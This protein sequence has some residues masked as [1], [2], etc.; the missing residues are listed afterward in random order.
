MD[1]PA[2]SLHNIRVKLVDLPVLL[3]Y[4]DESVRTEETKM[5]VIPSYE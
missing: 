2:D 5:R 4:S 3:E 1:H